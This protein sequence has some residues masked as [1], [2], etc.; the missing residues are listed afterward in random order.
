MNKQKL[1]SF[2]D[3]MKTVPE[4]E[5]DQ[6]QWFHHCGTPACIAGHAAVFFGWG[7]EG[8]SKVKKN[9]QMLLVS[10]AADKELGLSSNQSAWL[11]V[12]YPTDDDPVLV[13]QA[14]R[15]L[16]HLRDTGEVDWGII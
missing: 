14:V 13:S 1:Q 15:V 16:Q 12:G 10:E 5:Y 8:Y 9:E 4:S 3:Y 7:H 2:I 6:T 11:F